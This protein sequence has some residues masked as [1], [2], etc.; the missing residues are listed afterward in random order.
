MIM[1]KMETEVREASNVEQSFPFY[2]LSRLQNSFSKVVS[3][4]ENIFLQI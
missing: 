4:F 1:T 3:I 2:A